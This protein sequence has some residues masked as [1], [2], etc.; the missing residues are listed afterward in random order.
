MPTTR[1]P[2][3]ATRASAA[4]IRAVPMP[5]RWKACSTLK[6][7]T[8]G[9]PV[10]A[11]SGYDGR[12]QTVR[13]PATSP[14]TR[15]TIT[16]R[17]PDRASASYRSKVVRSFGQSSKAA[18][19]SS[20]SA[21]CRSS[22]VSPEVTPGLS[23]AAH[24]TSHPCR[25]GAARAGTCRAAGRQQSGTPG[26]QRRS[27]LQHRIGTRRQHGRHH[28]GRLGQHR[29]A[30]R[31]EHDAP[32]PHRVQRRGQQRPLERDQR[33]QV[34]ELASPARLG[35]PTQGAEAGARRVD[36]HPVERPG[37][38]RRPGA[39][40]G[41]HAQ[42][43]V[44]SPK[45]S[46]HELGAV[47]QPL[48]GHHAGP[49]LGRERGEQGGLAAGSGTEVQPAEVGP[50]ERRRGQGDRHQLRTLVLHPRPP[51]GD[52]R[53]RAR[54]AGRQVHAVRRPAR[55]LARQLLARRPAGTGHQRHAG[56]LVVRD[57]QGLDLRLPDRLREG[58]D[59]PPRV[60]VGDAQ[61]ADRVRGTVRRHPGH[62]IRRGRAP[63]PSSAPRWRSRRPPARR[64]S[65]PARPWC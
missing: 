22:I 36:Q 46:P 35:S 25:A 12:Q 29:R 42:H 32:G 9:M 23:A 28:A 13:Y 49:A 57:Q 3:A 4:S 1:W 65:A 21:G 15:A 47:R 61:V 58:L 11:K 14:A 20:T 38:P 54:V 27:I 7:R 34:R 41:H 55:G 10:A 45:R 2:A 6:S 37:R 50:V 18:A 48:V 19:R 30:R 5:R 44:G 31:V 56:R 63:R 24:R 39:V 51:L 52:G 59:D 8:S 60:G 16:S 40:P 33:V 43:A 26:K 64:R 17:S 62:P 53:D